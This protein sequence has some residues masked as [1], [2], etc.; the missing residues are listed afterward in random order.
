MADYLDVHRNTISN[1]TSGRTKIDTRTLTQTR[2]GLLL[3]PNTTS[4][5]KNESEWTLPL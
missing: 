5:P 3:L 1:Y 2:A 4:T